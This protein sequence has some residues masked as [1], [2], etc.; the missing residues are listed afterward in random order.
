MFAQM[1]NFKTKAV[2]STLSISLCL[3]FKIKI[4]S[5]QNFVLHFYHKIR[6]IIS[7][8]KKLF[9][10]LEYTLCCMKKQNI[11]QNEANTAKLYACSFRLYCCLATFCKC[12]VKASCKLC[13]TKTTSIYSLVHSLLFS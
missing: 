8:H 6:V 12:S 2:I 4:A 3:M 5:F 10:N 11:S 1:G 7:V 13:S 9:D